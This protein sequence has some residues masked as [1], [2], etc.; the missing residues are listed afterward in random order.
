[1]FSK[2]EKQVD[3]Y[4]EKRLPKADNARLVESIELGEPELK[5]STF[6]QSYYAYKVIIKC[7]PDLNVDSVE[8]RYSEFIWLHDW[9]VKLFPGIFIPPIPPKKVL[10]NKEAG[11]VA[12][13]R[14]DLQRFLQ[15]CCERKWIADSLPFQMFVSRP[16]FGTCCAYRAHCDVQF[17]WSLLCQSLS[18]LTPIN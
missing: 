6:A 11:F 5:S 2:P 13:R 15:R 3:A 14:E 17:R 7:S 16:G 18:P 12:E 8:R 10:G 9:L 4:A 1:L